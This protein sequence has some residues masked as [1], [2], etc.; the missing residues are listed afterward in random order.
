MGACFNCVSPQSSFISSML[1]HHRAKTVTP[2]PN[3][4]SLVSSRALA[5]TVVKKICCP[6]SLASHLLTSD[7]RHA[8][9]DCPT[10]AKICKNCLEEGHEAIECKNPKSI[11]TSDVADKT[12]AEAWELMKEASKT[13]DLDDFKDAVKI[14]LKAVPTYTY[15]Q[16]EKEYRSRGF[17][18]FTIAMEKDTLDTWTNC[19]LQGKIGKKYAVGYYFSAKPQRPSLVDKWPSSPEENMERLADAGV[20]MDRGVEKC[21]NWSVTC[22]SLKTTNTNLSIVANSV[23][24]FASAP[25]TSSPLSELPSLVPS[26]ARKVTASETALKSDR[27]LVSPVPARSARRPTTL[28]RIV[29]SARSVLGM[30]QCTSS[31]Y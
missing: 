19:D 18:V 16:L 23:I 7:S 29:P 22:P 8:A 15:P 13:R 26:V 2:R 25:K 21:N 24:P 27:S 11:D 14:L 4:P 28:P 3:A 17:T 6:E 1:T 30:L 5:R 10:K 31:C 12:E 20:P 9:R